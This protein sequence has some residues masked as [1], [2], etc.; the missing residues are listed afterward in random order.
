M[1]NKIWKG[2]FISIFRICFMKSM[3]KTPR[4]QKKQKK[5]PQVNTKKIKHPDNNQLLM[6]QKHNF[7]NNKISK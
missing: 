7:L 2:N 5:K 3:T 6:Q 1:G 4:M